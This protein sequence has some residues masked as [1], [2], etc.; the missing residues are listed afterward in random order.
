MLRSI[1][2]RQ[3]RDVRC[4]TADMLRGM[5][6][7]ARVMPWTPGCGSPVGGWTSWAEDQREGDGH[8][9]RVR[10]KT[11]ESPWTTVAKLPG[12]VNSHGHC[13]KRVAGHVDVSPL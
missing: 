1:A 7:P 12:A 11:T 2:G 13:M 6:R 3:M 8:Y 9:G 10:T 5:L 4:A